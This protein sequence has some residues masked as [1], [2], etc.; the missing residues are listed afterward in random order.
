MA[1]EKLARLQEQMRL[2]NERIAQRTSAAFIKEQ[3]RLSKASKQ[4]AKKKWQDK[5]NASLIPYAMTKEDPLYEMLPCAEKLESMKWMPRQTGQNM[6]IIRTPDKK[7]SVYGSHAKILQ[8]FLLDNRKC[9][10]DRHGRTKFEQICQNMFEIATAKSPQAQRCA[11]FLMERAF[12]TAKPSEEELESK[13]RTGYQIIVMPQA[14]LNI[15]T[16][17]LAL[18]AAP[19]PDFIDADFTE[20][21]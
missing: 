9:A 15:P 18:P 11:E 1:S 16:E 2:Q 10:T 14:K 17:E 13:K 20:V 6:N 19:E 3:T 21:Q 12:G 8:D 4:R 5:K 7:P